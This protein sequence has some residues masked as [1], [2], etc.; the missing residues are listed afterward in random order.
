MLREVTA[1][2][3]WLRK[4][5]ERTVLAVSTDGAGRPN[6]IALGW[7][8]PT[9][10]NPSMAVISV[11]LGRYSHRLIHEGGEFV[12]V[13]PSI[14]IEEDVLY[15]G[16]H[17]GREVDKFKETGLTPLPSKYVV[18]PLIKEGV[19][20]MECKVV[21]ELRTGD[22]TIF[23]GEILTAYISKEHKQALFNMGRDE[24]GRRKFRGF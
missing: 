17:S 13:F 8:M 10:H 15:C 3:A 16:T 4:Y 1:D 5:P 24:E 6:I 12:L 22:H 21:G 18:P 2:E 9:S 11:G 20:N 19:V 23:A 14:E 7:N